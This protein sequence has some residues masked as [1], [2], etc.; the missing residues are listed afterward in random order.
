MKLKNVTKNNIIDSEGSIAINYKNRSSSVD[1]QPIIRVLAEIYTKDKPV[2]LDNPDLEMRVVVTDTNVYVGS[3]IVE[4]KR[5]EF[6]KR[7][8][9][10]RPFFSP[11]SLH[12]KLARALVNLSSIKRNEKLLDPFCGTG[13]ILLE[14]GLIGTKIIGSDNKKE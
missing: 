3:K 7:K 12:P 6:E 5:G 10:H 9:Q 4:V 14:A 11:I 8:V 13:G 2:N 1:S